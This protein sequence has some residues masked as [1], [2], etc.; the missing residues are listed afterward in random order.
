MRIIK[1]KKKLISFIFLP[2]KWHLADKMYNTHKCSETSTWN[3]TVQNGIIILICRDRL[4]HIK[5]RK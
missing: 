4:Y 5:G 1:T 2:W 3:A